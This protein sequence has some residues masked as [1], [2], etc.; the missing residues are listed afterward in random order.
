MAIIFSNLFT[1]WKNGVKFQFFFNL[2][3]CSNYSVTNYFKIPVFHFL[4]CF[5]KVNK[6][7]LK[8]VNVSY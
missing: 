1:I 2:V 8:I 4:F 3:I 5:E 7:H 6:G